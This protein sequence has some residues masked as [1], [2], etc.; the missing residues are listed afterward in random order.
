MIFERGI[1][2]GS[3][4]VLGLGL[5]GCSMPLQRTPDEAVYTSEG[6]ASLTSFECAHSAV[7]SRGYAVRWYDGGQETLRAER[8]YG[9]GADTYRGYLTV[10]VTQDNS[11]R[12]LR[13]NAERWRD[14][15]RLPIPVNPTPP[16]PQPTPTPTPPLP[17]PVERRASH[18]VNPGPVANDARLV[19]ARCAVN[20]PRSSLAER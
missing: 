16:P 3:A 4:V 18:R 19:V 20:G 8:N 7:T 5:C 2:R 12:Y 17:R 6:A 15:S 1:V 13:V 11:G 9:D 14:T 10:Y